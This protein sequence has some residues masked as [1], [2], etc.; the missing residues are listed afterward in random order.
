[1]NVTCKV[2]TI[3]PEIAAKYL[4]KNE[5]NRTISQGVVDRY[6]RDMAAGRWRLTGETIVFGASGRL[7]NG[8]QRLWGCIESDTI[9]QVVVVRGI[10]DETAVMNV[11]DSGKA[12]TLGDVLKING[13]TETNRLG[14]IINTCWRY[15]N[16]VIFQP[17]WPSHEEALAWFA[18]NEGV[19]TAPGISKM[20]NR[21]LRTPGGPC[22]AAYYINARVDPEASE[23]FWQ[24]AATG[25]GLPAGSPILAYRRWVIQRLANRD[26][27]HANIWFA[28]NIKAMSLWRAG[29]K[30][31]IL[32][33]KPDEA[34]ARPWA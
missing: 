8:Q 1:M 26:Q 18:Q 28:Y 27:P 30:S 29:K 25:E 31:N 3:T 20:V 2:E 14:A 22:G 33:F 16:G 6:A 5:G 19:R 11:L 9:F 23:H 10:E 12:R 15:D 32:A 17:T 34:L 4:E 13:E 21:H 7:L 24:L